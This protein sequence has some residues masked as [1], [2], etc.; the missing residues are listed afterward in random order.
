M[1]EMRKKI[2]EEKEEE[3][4]KFKEQ[5]AENE[6][7]LQERSKTWEEKLAEGGDRMGEMNEQAKERKQMQERAK[8]DPHFSNLHED[9]SLNEKIFH[10]IGEKDGEVR[11]GKA[12]CEPPAQIVISGLNVQK[13]HATLKYDENGIVQLTPIGNAKCLINGEP[14][15]AGETVPLYHNYRVLFGNHHIFRFVHPGQEKL[16]RAMMKNKDILENPNKEE[17]EVVSESKQE[18]QD[19]SK[20]ADENDVESK[21]NESESKENEEDE[22]KESKNNDDDD[23]EKKPDDEDFS[24]DFEGDDENKESESKDNDESSLTLTDDEKALIEGKEF[25]EW[26]PGVLHVPTFEEAMA[27]I[28][29]LEMAAFKKQQEEEDR[30]RQEEQNEMES[31]LEKMRQKIEAE[32]KIAEEEK[33]KEREKLQVN[34]ISVFLN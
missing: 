32:R 1:E 14:V 33:E 10:F 12:N 24:D 5:L 27:E 26:M 16:G 31:Q 8:L 17:A 29:A 25:E 3:I 34:Y 9:E 18:D 30:K 23:E 15:P 22:E 6:K 21:E 20:T 7:L 2:E 11:V 4:R 28:S 19:E 13:E